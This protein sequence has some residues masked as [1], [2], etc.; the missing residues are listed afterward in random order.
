MDWLVNEHLI[1]LVNK[2]TYQGI[3]ELMLLV[4]VTF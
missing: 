1:E 4:E 2:I 3:F